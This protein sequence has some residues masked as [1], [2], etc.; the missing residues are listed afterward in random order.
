MG[1]RTLPNASP[2]PR[3]CRCLWRCRWRPRG[4]VHRTVT[5][6]NPLSIPVAVARA[7]A[8]AVAVAVAL[9]SSLVRVSV[10]LAQSTLC[11]ISSRVCCTAHASDWR[12]CWST[13]SSW[14]RRSCSLRSCEVREKGRKEVLARDG[15]SVIA[16]RFAGLRWTS[17]GLRWCAGGSRALPE[18]RAW[19]TEETA[20]R[21][22]RAA[23]GSGEK[24]GCWPE[25]GAAAG[26][27]EGRCLLFRSFC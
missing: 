4:R 3:S 25:R 21:S 26:D 7:V 10:G 2:L 20:A 13:W 14:L 12:C 27:A 11:E 15:C 16:S 17:G 8:V 1:L 5:E 24:R 22:T 19:R 18:S 23:F 6:S 9:E